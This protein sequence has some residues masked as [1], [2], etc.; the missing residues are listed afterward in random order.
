MDSTSDAAGYDYGPLTIGVHE[1]EAKRKT[2]VRSIMVLLSERAWTIVLIRA[3]SL[4]LPTWSWFW[5]VALIPTTVDGYYPTASPEERCCRV[6]N[7]CKMWL[8]VSPLNSCRW[9][10]GGACCSS[11]LTKSKSLLYRS[12]LSV[13]S[14]EW[15]IINLCW[16]NYLARCHNLITVNTNRLGLSARRDMRIM[17][18]SHSVRINRT[19]IHNIWLIVAEVSNTGFILLNIGQLI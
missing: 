12:C 8:R 16:Y 7:H 18:M 9:R 5:Y 3:W 6:Q 2:F 14:H 11:R 4:P 19:Y 13:L 1:N 15:P 17:P 10:R